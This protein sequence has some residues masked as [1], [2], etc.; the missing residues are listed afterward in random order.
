MYSIS[1]SLSNKLATFEIFR[2]YYWNH[3]N[4]YNVTIS[5]L[6]SKK[7]KYASL[8]YVKTSID[9]AHY[10]KLQYHLCSFGNNFLVGNSC[11]TFSCM[12][13]WI[14]ISWLKWFCKHRELLEFQVQHDVCMCFTNAHTSITYWIL[15]FGDHFFENLP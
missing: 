2:H 6:S 10:P 5:F 13:L 7:N 4:I 12:L 9:Y 1:S 11:R 14:K 15:K 8:S 3:R